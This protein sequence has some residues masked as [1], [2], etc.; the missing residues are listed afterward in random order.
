MTAASISVKE[1]MELRAHFVLPTQS[2]AC[3]GCQL[4]DFALL[5]RGF[6]RNQQRLW[7]VEDQDRIAEKVIRNLAKVSVERK[8]GESKWCRAIL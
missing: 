1:W 8:R 7:D 4:L 2:A 6:R 5:L 3:L